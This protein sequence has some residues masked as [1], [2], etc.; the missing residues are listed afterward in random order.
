MQG[1]KVERAY[2]E[3][4]PFGAKF[5][6]QREF[7]ESEFFYA[8]HYFSKDQTTLIDVPFTEIMQNY[9]SKLKPLESSLPECQQDLSESSVFRDWDRRALS[10]LH[11]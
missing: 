3:L 4:N 9:S 1:Q 2:I 5:I 8:L 7:L 6:L 11:Y 10:S